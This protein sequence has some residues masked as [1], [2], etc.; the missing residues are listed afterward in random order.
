[1][2]LARRKGNPGPPSRSLSGGASNGHSPSDQTPYKSWGNGSAM[3]VSPVG[4]AFDILEEVLD[5]AKGSAEITHDHPEG[6]QGAQAI[7]TAVFLARTGK[8]KE[9]IKS[10][11]ETTIN[12]QLD[13]PLDEIR[14]KYEFNVSC[15]KSVPRSTRMGQGVI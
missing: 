12:Y 3:R 1:M 15:Q 10:Y 14:P 13:T 8:N 9:Q 4:F 6:I 7:A 5:Q 2:R 11:I